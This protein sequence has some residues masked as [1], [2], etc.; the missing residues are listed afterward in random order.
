M[1]PPMNFDVIGVSYYVYKIIEIT[2]TNASIT[3][4]L[5]DIAKAHVCI[6]HCLLNKEPNLRFNLM[7]QTISITMLQNE[8]LP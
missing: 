4:I 1:F 8:S 7:S 3:Y 6:F 2:L 5:V